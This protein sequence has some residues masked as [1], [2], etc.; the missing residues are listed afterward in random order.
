MDNTGS[1]TITI[2][3]ELAYRVVME[4]EALDITPNGACTASPG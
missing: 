1:L 4:A 2:P 3:N